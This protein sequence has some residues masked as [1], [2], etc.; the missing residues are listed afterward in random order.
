MKFR[1]LGKKGPRVSAMGY[2][3]MSISEFYGKPASRKEGVKFIQGAFNDCGITFF[4]TADMYGRG[5]SEEMVGEAFASNRDQ[6]VVA[7]KCGIVRAEEGV[8]TEG[9]N[10]TPE[11]IKQ[12]CD[13]SLKRLGMDHV[14]VYYLHR[15]DT[16][17]PIEVAMGAMQ[18][19]IDAGKIRYVGLS[20]VGVETIRKAHAVLGEKLVALQSE[21][22]IKSRGTAELV[23]PTCRELGIGFVAYSPVG[24]GLLSGIIRDSA[25]LGK[26]AFDFRPL[27][28]QFA[29]ENLDV[30]L[31][32]VDAISAIAKKTG[33]TAAQISLAWLLAQGEDI[34]PIPGTM[35]LKHLKE[36]VAAVNITLSQ[37]QLEALKQVIQENPIMGSRYPDGMM[38]MFNMI[39]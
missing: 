3:C 18:E 11:Y 20:E 27:L 28:P 1:T 37:E 4:D 2:G 36:N 19:L 9:L 13:K 5:Y 7:T 23:L 22:S 21:Y 39:D 6:V 24:R 25:S 31:R 34:I 8:L 14:D 10:S 29:Q 15:H 26:E 16:T 38:K 33:H 35:N 32:F 12:S 30:N 17:T